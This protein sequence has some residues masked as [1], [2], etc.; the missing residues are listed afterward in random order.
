ML[1]RPGGPLPPLFIL[2][3]ASRSLPDRVR[4]LACVFVFLLASYVDQ[5][6]W[7]KSRGG[8]VASPCKSMRALSG[9]GR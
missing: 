1:A 4:S 2:A 3:S 8:E 7:I 9:Y 5:T 6:R